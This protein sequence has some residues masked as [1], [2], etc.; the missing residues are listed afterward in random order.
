VQF[1][2]L[3][4]QGARTNTQL[5]GSVGFDMTGELTFAPVPRTVRGSKTPPS[6]YE[7]RLS[8]P[9]ESPTVVVQ[10]LNVVIGKSR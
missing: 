6:T 2:A 4:L 7:L 8:G 1:R 10:S 5:T 3:R 9:L